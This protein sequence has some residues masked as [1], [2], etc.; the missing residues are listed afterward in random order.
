MGNRWTW[1]VNWDKDSCNLTR[2]AVWALAGTQRCALG[3]TQ[4]ATLDASLAYE[5][6]GFGGPDAIEGLTSH[7]ERREPSFPS[8]AER[9]VGS[10]TS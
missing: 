3:H 4:S 6:L 2:R 7:L 1:P 9:E 8:A 10:A 5:F